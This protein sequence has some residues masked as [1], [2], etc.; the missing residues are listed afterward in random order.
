MGRKIFRFEPWWQKKH[1]FA[2][3]VKQVWQVKTRHLDTWGVLKTKIS[4][5]QHMSPVE[6]I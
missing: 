6:E 2:K 3:E 5:T 4:N 1:G